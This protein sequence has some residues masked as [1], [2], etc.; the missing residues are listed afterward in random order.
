M[1][2]FTLQNMALAYLMAVLLLGGASAAG[3]NANLFLQLAGAALI[4]LFCWRAEFEPIGSRIFWIFVGALSLLAA[5]QLVPL[6]PSL[7]GDLPGRDRIIDGYNL[8]GM[9]PP[10]LTLS[11]SPWN[12]IGSLAWCIP[13]LAMFVITRSNKAPGID[14][15]AKYIG[16]FAALSALVGIVQKMTGGGYFYAVTNYGQGPGFFANSNHQGSFLLVALILY[17][18]Q[19]IDAKNRRGQRFSMARLPWWDISICALFIIGILASNSLA[20]QAMLV[21]VI[22]GI[23]F[24][25]RD[26]WRLPW[27]LMIIAGLS[28]AG[29]LT[30]FVLL[31]PVSND[32]TAKGV[33]EGIS[34]KDFL[35][36][37]LRIVAD[38]SPFGTGLGS[39][40]DIYRWYE[41]PAVVG[42][43]YVNHA[44]ND[45]L[46]LFIE[47]GAFSVLA[48]FLF[49]CWFIPCGW[50]L[51]LGQRKDA[52][53]LAATIVI[54]TEMLHSIVDYPLRTAALSALFAIA[55]AHLAKAQSYTR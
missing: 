37:G 6:P 16:Y 14:I 47:T 28:L 55:I 54:A 19:R 31:G 49:L 33:V 44:H 22:L 38:F 17:C 23:V 21:P 50:R 34:R 3:L 45:Y 9:K 18:A 8:L 2:L 35:L 20:C 51:W 53:A 41:D 26:D 43:T 24:M 7:W 1:K 25:A 40:Q 12:S 32:L 15:T 4:L 36:T 29:A 13:A 5:I 52:M 10:W 11:L 30:A 46:E 27:P 48:L 39:F 42:T